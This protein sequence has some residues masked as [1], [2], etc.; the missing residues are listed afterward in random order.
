MATKIAPKSMKNQACVADAFL[1]RFGAA[2]GRPKGAPITFVWAALAAIF[3]QKRDFRKYTGALRQPG[4]FKG[5]IFL[6]FG[7]PFFE[8]NFWIDF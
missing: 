7:H 3:D 6:I 4:A 1:E 2:L 5:W 8:L